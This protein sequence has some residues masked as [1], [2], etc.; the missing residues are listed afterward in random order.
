MAEHGMSVTVFPVLGSTCRAYLQEVINTCKGGEVRLVG[1]GL[2]G[3]WL[4]RVRLV[5]NDDK[6][7]PGN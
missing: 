3:A 2:L 4:V 6:R 1:V 7:F 5:A